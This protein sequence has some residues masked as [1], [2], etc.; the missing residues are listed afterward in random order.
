MVKPA[1]GL[2][3]RLTDELCE[4][5]A[6]GDTEAEGD[7]EALWLWVPREGLGEREGETE[8]ET[9]GLKLAEGD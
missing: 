5:L 7:G 2:G 6:L 1:D 8:G 4:R 3:L 9:L